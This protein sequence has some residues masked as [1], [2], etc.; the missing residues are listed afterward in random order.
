MAQIIPPE[1]MEV[2]NGA[3]AKLVMLAYEATDGAVEAVASTTPEELE[4]ARQV[5]TVVFA[6]NAVLQSVNLS[7]FGA[8][9]AAAAVSGTI[10]GQCAGNRQ[11]LYEIFRRQMAATLAEV[12]AGQMKP[13]GNA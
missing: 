2:L 12:A 7:E 9:I 5:Q 6:M 4:Q 8:L 3:A 10:M 1:I 13:M 11:T